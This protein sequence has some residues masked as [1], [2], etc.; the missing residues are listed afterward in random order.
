MWL[1]QTIVLVVALLRDTQGVLID[2][3]AFSEELDTIAIFGLKHSAL[4]VGSDLTLISLLVVNA[5]LGINQ[6]II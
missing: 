2:G 3:A 1:L 5:A 4:Q 6:G